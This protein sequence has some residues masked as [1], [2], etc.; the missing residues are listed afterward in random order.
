VYASIYDL[1]NTPTG[2]RQQVTGFRICVGMY[3][4]GGTTESKGH[5]PTAKAAGLSLDEPEDA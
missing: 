2:I 3:L 1:G 5:E 4:L